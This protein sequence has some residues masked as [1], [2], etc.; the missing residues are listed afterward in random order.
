MEYQDL[1]RFSLSSHVNTESRYGIKSCFRFFLLAYK[2]IIQQGSIQWNKLIKENWKCFQKYST[3]FVTEKINCFID[4][5]PQRQKLDVCEFNL[6]WTE[7]HNMKIAWLHWNMFHN[8]QTQKILSRREKNKYKK[9][10]LLPSICFTL[11]TI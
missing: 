1:P 10:T 11:I 3:E 6:T 2:S 9:K 7:S 4:F 5:F 8:K